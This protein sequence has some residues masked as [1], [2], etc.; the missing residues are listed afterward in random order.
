MSGGDP[1]VV[2]LAHDLARNFANLPKGDAA[3]ELATHIDKFWEP[4]MIDEL[5]E[6]VDADDGSIDPIVV[7]AAKELRE[8]EIDEAELVEPSGG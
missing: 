8:N 2:R 7:A 5:L 6:H 3:I 4:R 1:A